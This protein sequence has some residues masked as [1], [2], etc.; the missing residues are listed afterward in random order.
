MH[1]RFVESYGR[2]GRTRHQ[3]DAASPAIS[4]TGEKRYPRLG[5]L[6]FGRVGY[7]RASM[8]TASRSRSM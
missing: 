8:A 6:T 1:C 3:A 5:A 2:F 4:S 7:S